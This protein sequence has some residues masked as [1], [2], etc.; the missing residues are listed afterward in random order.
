[1]SCSSIGSFYS[2]SKYPKCKY[3]VWDEPIAEKCPKCGWPILTLK[4]TKRRG[5][6]KICPQ[7]E[8]GFGKN[9]TNTKV[10]KKK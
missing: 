2:C 8:C 5:Q 9:K 6:E 10:D 4:T 3:A 1:M 7:K